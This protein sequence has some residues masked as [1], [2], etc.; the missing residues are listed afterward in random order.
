M[1]GRFTMARDLLHVA[2][3]TNS[4]GSPSPYVPLMSPYPTRDMKGH[5]V[6]LRVNSGK[7][8]DPTLIEEVSE[9]L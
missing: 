8:D 7:I 1:C 4:L 9:I 6:S 5:P 2:Q 3:K